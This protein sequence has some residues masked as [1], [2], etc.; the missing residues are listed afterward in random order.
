M[1]VRPDNSGLPF[2]L[3]GL[4]G[5]LVS[6]RITVEPKL[7]EELLE[8]LSSLNFPVNPQLYHRHAQVSVEFPAYSTQVEQVRDAL[9]YNGFDSNSLESAAVL[10]MAH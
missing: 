3:F 7:L 1:S 4:E 10:T 5:E 2:A 6:L 8:A 9:R